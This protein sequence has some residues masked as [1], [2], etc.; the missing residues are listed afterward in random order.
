MSPEE[1][2]DAILDEA[3]RVQDLSANPKDQEVREQYLDLI[4]PGEDE[5]KR[6][7]MA[8]MSGC[9][10][11]VAGLWRGA[12]IVHPLLDPPYKIGSAVTRLIQIAQ[13]E[14]AWK[15]YHLGDLP[16]VGDM[17]LIESDRG[18]EHVYTV[19]DVEE[20]SIH[21]IDGGQRDEEGYQAIKIKDRVWDK[22]RDTVTQG[23]EPGPA[24]E[25]SSA[26]SL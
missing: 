8:V 7:D 19:L 23:T 25:G 21:S 20:G 2:R 24:V 22:G 4:A 17:V 14:W 15:P 6:R 16:E 10:L 13:R 1:L 12:G 26:S 18:V 3:E 9:A 11:V 5:N